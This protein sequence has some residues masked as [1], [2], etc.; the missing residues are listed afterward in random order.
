MGDE[1]K[2]LLAGDESEIKPFE[3]DGVK[4]GVLICFELRYKEL[5]KK[6]E[7]CDVILLPS[8]WGEPRKRHLEILSQALA[9]MNQCFVLVANSVQERIWQNQAL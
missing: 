3:I 7:G 2:H 8:Q 4:Y 1:D 9:I 6:L 5:W